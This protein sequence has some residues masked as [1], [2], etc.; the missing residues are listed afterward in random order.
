[1]SDHE[2]NNKYGITEELVRELILVKKLTT[3]EAAKEIGCSQCNFCYWMKKFNIQAIFKKGS[4]EHLERMG[5]GRL[6]Y[7]GK[8]PRK[9]RIQRFLNIIDYN[10]DEIQRFYDTD[11]TWKQVRDKFGCSLVLISHA[12]KIDLFK[13]RTKEEN[14]KLASINSKCRKH[15]D[16]T[17]IKLSIARK[18]YL[19]KNNK[20]A[21]KTHDKFKSQPC[22]WLKSELRNKDYAFVE[23]LQPLRHLKRFF[24]MD[25]AFPEV[26]F[27][28]EINGGQHYDTNGELKPYYQN[29]HDLIKKEGWEIWEVK[30]HETRS[31]LFLQRA[32]EVL[33]I[34]GVRPVVIETT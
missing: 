11:K 30:Y 19:P 23:E 25:I 21:W 28:I 9:E 22:E 17:K 1:M 3:H 12:R 20:P 4:K 10:W 16:E 6:K 27:A 32:L 5:K 7:E 14:C 31:P 24:S 2:Y 29:R 15:S 8:R 18:E 34:K 13:T 26:K 33:K